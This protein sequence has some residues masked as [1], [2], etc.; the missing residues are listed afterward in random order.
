MVYIDESE[1]IEHTKLK[2]LTIALAVSDDYKILGVKVGKIP[3]C[4]IHYFR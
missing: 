4:L 2:P 3:G 1:S